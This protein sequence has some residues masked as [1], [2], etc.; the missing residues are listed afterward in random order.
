MIPD[1]PPQE[2]E[3]SNCFLISKRKYRFWYQTNCPELTQRPEMVVVWS[4]GKLQCQN[5]VQ[6]PSFAIYAN[7]I[8]SGSQAPPW[9]N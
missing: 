4:L 1:D 6:L 8:G 5:S 9:C 7:A 2:T 3:D